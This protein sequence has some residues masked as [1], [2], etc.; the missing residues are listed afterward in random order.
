MTL[1]KYNPSRYRPALFNNFVDRF[2]NE[3]FNG[4][5]TAAFSP[6]VDIAETDKNFEIE[7]TLPGMKKDNIN[8]DVKDDRLTINGERKIEKEKKEKNF[9]SV[10]SNYGSFSRSFYLPDTVNTEKIDASYKD[11]I[12][13][14][15]LPKD[16]KKI[17]SQTIAIK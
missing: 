14:V 2:F 3:E 11:G 12:L 4:N 7:V 17:L 1:V 8:I 9:H 16:E 10:E 13:S 15:T 5:N 6:K